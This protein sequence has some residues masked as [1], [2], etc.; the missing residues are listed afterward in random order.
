MSSTF[1]TPIRIFKRNN[2]TNDGTIAPDNTGASVCTQQV[3]FVG[4]TAATLTLP[5]GAIVHSFT[6]YVAT[7]A[8][9]PSATNVTLGGTTVATLSDAAGVN[10]G[11]LTA[12]QA[13]LLANIGTTDK[14]VSFT[15]GA[16]A[17]GV[18]S[19]M[20]TPRNPDGTIT[21]VGNGY[22]NN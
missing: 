10:T 8:G 2:P 9:S 21:P 16:S 18:L 22:T 15:A 6:S 20:Y 13:A 14:T 5:A 7:A 19:V 17:I 4:G 12:G 11:T 3:A 1:N